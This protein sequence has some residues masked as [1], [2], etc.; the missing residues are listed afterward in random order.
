M[1]KNKRLDDIQETLTEI[2]DLL[3]NQV[4]R[5]QAFALMQDTL[6]IADTLKTIQLDLEIIKVKTIFQ[7][8]PE[9]EAV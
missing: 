6:K 1:F 3:K 4:S 7:K 5:S 8:Q 2:R 9:K